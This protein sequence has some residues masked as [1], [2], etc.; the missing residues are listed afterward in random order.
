MQMN[1]EIGHA[2]DGKPPAPGCGARSAT[3][4]S[5][6]QR[7]DY[8]AQ[9]S[10]IVGQHVW[11]L[12]G[13]QMHAA[14]IES[15]NGSV[16]T[17]QWDSTKT[18]DKVSPDIIMPMHQESNGHT[19]SSN[20]SKRI[21]KRHVPFSPPLSIGSRQ[22]RDK[23]HV[24]SAARKSKYKSMKRARKS[25]PCHGRDMDEDLGDKDQPSPSD[26][27]AKVLSKA[28]K[29]VTLQARKSNQV[30]DMDEDLDGKDQSSPSGVRGK[31]LSKAMK[32][33][34]L[35]PPSTERE[36]YESL[37]NH[38]MKPM[39]REEEELP[40]GITLRRRRAQPNLL[41]FKNSKFRIRL[42]REILRLGRLGRK[43]E[44]NEMLRLLHDH[45]MK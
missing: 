13:R 17:V 1:G 30:R 8:D 44:I 43:E 14:V 24:S 6:D 9:L 45:G 7:S 37:Y 5:T 20:F 10:F 16:I 31:V 3:D 25:A 23:V 33:I 29:L 35:Q 39:I 12:N 26:T 40:S 27:K 28:T 18:R 2:G 4:R 32:P 22:R 34:A 11:V 41:R 21:R 36:E 15:I 38:Y 42:H 19:I